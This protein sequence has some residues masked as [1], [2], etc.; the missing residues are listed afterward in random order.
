M[1]VYNALASVIPPSLHAPSYLFSW[2]PGMT[3]LSTTKEVAI[4]MATYFLVIFSGRELMRFVHVYLS[5]V[6]LVR[7][8]SRAFFTSLADAFGRWSEHVPRR[9]PTSVE[10]VAELS[11]EPG[12]L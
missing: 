12:S 9:A 1:S 6:E 5:A 10:S 8:W 11:L 3:P 7:P 2:Q 4:A